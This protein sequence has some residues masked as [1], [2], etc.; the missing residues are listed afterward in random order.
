MHSW[1]S[2]DRQKA[3]RIFRSVIKLDRNFHNYVHGNLKLIEKRYDE[4][5]GMNYYKV[6]FKEET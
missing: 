4:A 3:T 2:E 5:T 1:G 6:Y